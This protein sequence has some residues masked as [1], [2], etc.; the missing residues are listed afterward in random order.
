[1]LSL[2]T[3]GVLSTNCGKAAKD[4]GTV[5]GSL[6]NGSGGSGADAL[7]AGAQVAKNNPN[8]AIQQT[9]YITTDL[10]AYDGSTTFIAYDANIAN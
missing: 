7:L 4:F 2:I 10:P 9:T 3:V 8:L 6:V 1:M 5:S